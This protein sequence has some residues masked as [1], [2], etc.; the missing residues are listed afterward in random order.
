MSE[1]N[2]PFN[3]QGQSESVDS[4][5]KRQNPSAKKIQPIDPLSV[6]AERFSFNADNGVEVDDAQDGVRMAE[7][8][9]TAI[10]WQTWQSSRRGETSDPLSLVEPPDLADLVSLIQELNQCNSILLDRVS[11]L[12]E[13]LERSQTALQAEVGRSQDSPF[14]LD[15]QDSITMPEQLNSLYNQL[16]FAQQTNQRQQILIETLTEQLETSQERVA[17]LEREAALVQQRY[18][19][20]TQLLSQSE[21]N[22]RDLQARL[23]R[24]QRYTLQ[25]KAALEKCLEVP[26]LQYESA[27]EEVVTSDQSFLPKVHQI[28]PWSTP[29]ELS[30]MLLPWMKVSAEELAEDS[31][32]DV[33]EATIDL[34]AVVSFEPNDAQ[35]EVNASETERSP[36]HLNLMA[37]DLPT[38]LGEA[39]NVTAEPIPPLSSEPVVEEE[40]EIAF[41]EPHSA[42]LPISYNLKPTADNADETTSDS[43]IQKLDAAVQPLAAM[44]AEAMLAGDR[45]SSA[46]DVQGDVNTNAASASVTDRSQADELLESVMTDAEGALWQDLARLI[47]VSTEEV[48][49]ASLSGDF[50]AFESINFEALHGEQ[51]TDDSL[52]V[53]Q[54]RSQERSQSDFDRVQ[55]AAINESSIVSQPAISMPANPSTSPTPPTPPKM[56]LIPALAGN[57][58]SPSPIVYPW[59]TQKKNRSRSMV[60]LPSFLRQDTRPLPT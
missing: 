4:T 29:S 39:P 36:S 54:E 37:I 14:A 34:E 13:A 49:K 57:S 45:S 3:P 44:L 19:E 16:E 27:S 11:Q 32:M 2:T 24:Q 17:E 59:R 40:A 46:T 7:V 31:L 33:V 10:G 50:S 55:P 51:P 35:T 47:N 23:Q 21:N 28:Q 48:V 20:Q 56:P 43:L 60:D 1:A 8:S 42:V 15:S 12:E 41:A 58:S 26:T 5:L 53:S 52:N 25:F 30:T 38:F 22:G 9:E 6:P 18:N